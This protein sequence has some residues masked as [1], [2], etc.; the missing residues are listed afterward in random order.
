MFSEKQISRWKVELRADCYVLY[1]RGSFAGV[2]VGLYANISLK[3]AYADRRK[4]A[5]AAV[6][7]FDRLCLHV[8]DA[9]QVT[10]LPARAA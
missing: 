3:A 8:D 7:R 6:E 10:R 2:C 9:G 1:Y 4:E 5:R